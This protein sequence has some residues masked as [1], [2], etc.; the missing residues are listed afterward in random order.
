[1]SCSSSSSLALSSTG[2]KA[3]K[4]TRREREGEKTD[5]GWAKRKL[6]PVDVLLLRSLLLRTFLGVSG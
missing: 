6:G 1:V 3:R 5:G 4:N 2:S